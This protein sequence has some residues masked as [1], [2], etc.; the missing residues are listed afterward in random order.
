[1]RQPGELF[2]AWRML[3]KSLLECIRK[4]GGREKAQI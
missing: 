1:M 3:I 2:G 4:D